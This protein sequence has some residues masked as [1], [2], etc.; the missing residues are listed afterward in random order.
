MEKEQGNTEITL[1]ALHEDD[2][3]ESDD[4]LGAEDMPPS[5]APQP[6][7]NVEELE[8]RIR[9]CAE[10]ELQK[11]TGQA[12]ALKNL[13]DKYKYMYEQLVEKLSRRQAGHQEQIEAFGRDFLE[14]ENKKVYTG[15]FGTVR[16][17]A[18]QYEHAIVDKKVF[19]E[20]A[21]K[22][23]PHLMTTE[24]KQVDTPDRKVLDGH[25]KRTGEL[26]PGVMPQEK[27]GFSIKYDTSGITG[28]EE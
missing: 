3:W 16:I 14:K 23:A 26:P 2:N 7:T 28:Y 8:E 15:A 13:A 1:E 18:R 20:W 19:V 21:L 24:L 11:S 6:I 5:W 17:T 22:N 12:L 9:M 4:P 10:L 25:I 27:N